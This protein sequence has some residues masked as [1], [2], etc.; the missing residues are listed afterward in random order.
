MKTRLQIIDDYLRRFYDGETTPAENG[1]LSDMLHALDDSELTP[2]LRDERDFLDSM[3]G[4]GGIPEMPADLERRILEA[5]VGRKGT[6]NHGLS[7]SERFLR[8][9]ACAASL[10]LVSVMVWWFM[11]GNGHAIVNREVMAVAGAGD[12][13]D[14]VIAVPLLKPDTAA[15]EPAK[16]FRTG[17]LTHQAVADIREKQEKRP[18]VSTVEIEN[19]T[20]VADSV[21]SMKITM[22]AMA[23]IDRTLEKAGRIG[24]GS[25]EKSINDCSGHIETVRKTINNALL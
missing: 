20:V 8:Y 11:D 4:A 22:M 6:R 7:R 5:T 19:T 2:R 23:I 15:T 21:E 14:D 24:V 3:A 17:T 13:A 16:T 10:I 1:M 9:A 18:A 25:A 12:V